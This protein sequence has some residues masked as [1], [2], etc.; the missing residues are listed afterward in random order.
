MSF[1]EDMKAWGLGKWKLR[2]VKG[3]RC[4]GVAVRG[5]KTIGI[6]YNLLRTPEE[7]R[8]TFVHECAHAKMMEAGNKCR[9]QH[10]REWQR[11]ALSL[12][13][14]NPTATD[15]ISYT[16][17]IKKL[18]HPFKIICPKCKTTYAS[19]KYLGKNVSSIRT[20][21]KKYLQGYCRYCSPY[22]HLEVET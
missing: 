4:L 10:G 12:G 3:Y 5:T 17:D 1:E 22:T 21:F 9:P 8:R 7:Q 19:G 6:N 20:R 16:G 14:D 13:M 18:Y 2:P 15:A 11:M